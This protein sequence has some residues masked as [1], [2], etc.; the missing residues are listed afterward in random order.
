MSLLTLAPGRSTALA[1]DG[2][3][4]DLPCVTGVTALTLGAGAPNDANGQLL[5]LIRLTIAPGGGF[6][7]HT[8]PGMMVVSVESGTVDV[9]QIGDMEMTVTRAASNGTPEVSEPLTNGMMATLNPGDSFVEPAGM[10]H[11]A[12]N[13]GS[14]SAVLLATGL[15]D[16]NQPAT[17]CVEGTPTA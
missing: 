14:E 1:Q 12:F 17:Q 15:I 4:I 2:Q 7:P 3:P 11:T 8:H 13:N 5:V 16:P 10:V 9:T 6:S